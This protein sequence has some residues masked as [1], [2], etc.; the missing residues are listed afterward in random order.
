MRAAR[1]LSVVKHP[2]RGRHASKIM[3]ERGM[4]T[5]ED[6]REL[7][8]KTRIRQADVAR[9]FEVNSRTVQRWA[10]D[11]DYPPPKAIVVCLKLILDGRLT[12][13]EV[14]KL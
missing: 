4:M 13:E 1:S 3:K 10:S 7:L 5:P 2:A 9:L 6:F 11:A 8:T 14:T 12:P